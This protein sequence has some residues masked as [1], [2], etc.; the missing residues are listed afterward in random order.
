VSGRTGD[1]QNIVVEGDCG[2][3]QSAAVHG[4]ASQQVDGGLAQDVAFKMEGCS[5]TGVTSDL[6]M[7]KA[8]RTC[9]PSSAAGIMESF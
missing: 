8:A 7:M 6:R 9:T 5:E 4:S 2:L 3:G 1:Y